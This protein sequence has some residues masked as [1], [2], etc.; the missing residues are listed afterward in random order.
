MAG[1]GGSTVGE[2]RNILPVVLAQVEQETVVVVVDA[3]VE[4]T[5]IVDMAEARVHIDVETTTE[6][7]DIAEDEEAKIKLVD[8]AKLEVTTQTTEI[9]TKVDDIELYSAAGFRNSQE[10]KSEKKELMKKECV[11][12]GYNEHCQTFEVEVETIVEEKICHNI[13]TVVC[14]AP[15]VG[16]G[17]KEKPETMK[18]ELVRSGEEAE[19]T[20]TVPLADTESMD[21][22]TVKN[23]AGRRKSIVVKTEQKPTRRML[24]YGRGLDC[25]EKVSEVCYSS[26]RVEKAT[27]PKDFCWVSFNQI[28]A[29]FEVD[30]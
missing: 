26:Q 21:T 9:V 23:I 7:A 12:S 28:F 20:S 4:M 5:G 13:T 8:N 1:G 29:G 15:L 22:T 17:G 27:R 14:E 19:T 3:E 2:A 11:I 16:S 6:A 25:T 30:L 24:V 18:Q 10:C